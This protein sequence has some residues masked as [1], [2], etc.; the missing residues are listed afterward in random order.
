[1]KRSPLSII[2]LALTLAACQTEPATPD[3]VD[4]TTAMAETPMTATATLNPTEGNSAS[5][6]ITF[7]Q[8]NGMVRV[9]GMIM[10][11][12]PGEHGFHVHENGD[13][14]AADLP[15]DP[16]SEPNPAGA[17]GGHFAPQGSPHGA[18]GNDAAARHVGDLGNVT[19]GA[20]GTAMVSMTDAVIALDGPNSIV[21]K[22]LLVHAGQ[23]DLTSQ[24]SGAAG[25]RVAC[26]VITLG[27]AGMMEI[28]PDTTTAM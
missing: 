5:G 16:D 7:T 21:G 28:R 26:G 3:V 4:D 23:D 19:A 27:G 6:Q 1:M 15:D 14:S 13:C 12:S 8:E 20:D 22:A 9:E 24:P 2:A 17:A 10:G 18:P 25:A 11:L